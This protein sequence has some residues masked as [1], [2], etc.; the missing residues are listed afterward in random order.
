MPRTMIPAVLAAVLTFS[1]V[2]STAIRQGH[3]DVPVAATADDIQPLGAGDQAPRFVVQTVE[4][5]TFDFNPGELD[6]PAL[7]LVFR[8]GWCSA[9]FGVWLTPA[10]IRAPD[11]K[12]ARG[13]RWSV[14]VEKA[15]AAALELLFGY[16][17]R[18]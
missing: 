15:V 1:L 9:C 4:S 16:P 18:R 17:D 13:T 8:G 14:L 2:C 12:L 7:I 5:R 10:E 6:K 11:R 3:A